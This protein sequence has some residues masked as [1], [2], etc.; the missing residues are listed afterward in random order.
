MLLIL[1]SQFIS[2]LYKPNTLQNFTSVPHPLQ[3][4]GTI[5]ISTKLISEI[6]LLVS[7]MPLSHGTQVLITVFTAS[8]IKILISI[9]ARQ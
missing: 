4:L 2:P 7:K 1:L 3:W 8:Y 6:L 5:K 9:S